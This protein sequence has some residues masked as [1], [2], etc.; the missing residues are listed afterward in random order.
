MLYEND[1]ILNNNF[2]ISLGTIMTISKDR[3][4]STHFQ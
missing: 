2:H 3:A 4:N 1:V